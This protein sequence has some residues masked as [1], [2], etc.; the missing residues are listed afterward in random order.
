VAGVDVLTAQ[1]V[2]FDLAM[3]VVQYADRASS[4]TAAPRP[5]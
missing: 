5:A 2:N 4:A 3:K 1:R